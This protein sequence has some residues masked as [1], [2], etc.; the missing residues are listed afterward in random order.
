MINPE[1][2]G[3]NPNSDW[4]FGKQFNAYYTDPAA[5]G[6]WEKTKS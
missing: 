2:S 6:V 5:V 4:A 3:Y 1:T